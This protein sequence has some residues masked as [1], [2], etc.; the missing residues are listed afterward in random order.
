MRFENRKIHGTAK[1]EFIFF[2]FAGM[3]QFPS[4]F[5]FLWVQ[6][7]LNGDLIVTLKKET[8]SLVKIVFL[9][10]KLTMNFKKG[11]QVWLPIYA[12]SSTRVFSLQGVVILL[13]KIQLCTQ[14]DL[15]RGLCKK[16]QT[17]KK[18]AFQ[19]IASGFRNVK[20]EGGLLI[21]SN[22]EPK[23]RGRK[24]FKPHDVHPQNQQ[25]TFFAFISE[26]ISVWSYLVWSEIPNKPHV[27]LA[28]S[29]KDEWRTGRLARNWRNW[30]ET[31]RLRALAE[32]QVRKEGTTLSWIYIHTR[33]NVHERRQGDGET[34][35]KIHTTLP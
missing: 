16:L 14:K 9:H 21:L 29:R 30:T 20:I 27:N 11:D 7:Y 17:W 1:W 32:S 22:A 3:A 25:N 28:F 8:Q 5:V 26:N 18:P 19:F 34:N 24:L 33:M 6:L 2:S 4:S 31:S 13:T 35:G 23:P 15:Q 10:S 12:L